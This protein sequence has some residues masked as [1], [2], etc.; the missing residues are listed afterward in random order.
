MSVTL[1]RRMATLLALGSALLAVSPVQAQNLTLG[2]KLEL[3]TLDPHFF[4]AFPTGSSHPLIYEQLIALDEKLQLKPNL[5]LS[6]K[7][8]DPLTWEVKLRQGVV[9][10]NGAPFTADDVIFTWER[11]P[12]VPNSPNSFSQFTRSVERITKVDSHTLHM[13][14]V[15][16]HPGLPMDLANVLIISASVGKGATTQ[17]FN[18]GKAAVGTGPFKLVEWVNG[19]RLVVERNERYWGPKPSWSRVTEV[20]LAKDSARLAALMSGQVDA[21]DAVP[22]ADLA[23]LKRENRFSLVRGGPG[24]TG[25]LH[26]A[27]LRARRIALHHRQGRQAPGPQPAQGRSRA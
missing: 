26:R 4:A 24:R 16:V 8:L 3:N 17:D 27:G 18:S 1:I 23:R 6:W 25:A 14:T 15:A 7:T 21:I 19:E 12:N 20:V 13:K 10:H 2:T 22:S 9:F 5:A 11:V